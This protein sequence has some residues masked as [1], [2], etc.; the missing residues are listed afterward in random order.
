MKQTQI[1]GQTY[2]NVEDVCDWMLKDMDKVPEQYKREAK[3]VRAA[4][5]ILREWGR[6]PKRK[7]GVPNLTMEVHP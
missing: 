4:C 3:A 2:V 5:E 6:D 7:E 1:N